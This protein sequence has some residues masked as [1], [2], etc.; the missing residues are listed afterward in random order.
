MRKGLGTSIYTLAGVLLVAIFTLFL[1]VT[2]SENQADNL[3][4]IATADKSFNS[5]IE[6]RRLYTTSFPVP[7]EDNIDVV[8][9]VSYGCEYGDPTEDYAFEISDPEEIYIETENFLESYF[10]K[11]LEANYQFKADCGSNG[12]I[13]VG[14]NIP[15]NPDRVISSI[16]EIPSPNGNRTEVILRRW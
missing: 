15:S 13:I 5:E 6:L 9:A 2:Q 14:E 12:E 7:R 8:T 1:F 16:L 11:T 10:N 4:T 3:R